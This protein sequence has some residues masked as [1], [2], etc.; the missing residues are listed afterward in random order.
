MIRNLTHAHWAGAWLLLFISFAVQAQTELRQLAGPKKVFIGN[1]I[2]NEHLNAPDTFRGGLADQHLIEQYNAV[3]LENYMK[4]R[5][6]LPNQSPANIHDLT[7]Q[8]LYDIMQKDRVMAFLNNPNW[9][10][11][12]KRGIAI[13]FNQAPS[14]LNIEAPAWTG[15]QVFDFSRKYIM[16][17]GQLCGDH[18]EEWDVINEAIA[19]SPTNGIRGWRQN[20]WYRRANDGSMTDWGV[21]TYENYIKMLFV[22]MREAQ[23]EARLHI[24]DYSIEHYETGLDSKNR[25]MREKVKALKDCGAPID[26]VGFQSHLLLSQMVTEQG[27]VDQSFINQIQQSMADLHDAGLEVAITELDIRI[28]NEDRDEAYQEAAFQA[29]CEM[30][31]SQPNCHEII[32]WGLRDE[33]NWITNINY[34]VFAGCQDPVLAEGAN[35]TLKAAFDGVANAITSLPDESN[36]NFSPLNPGDGETADCGGVGEILPSVFHVNGPQVVGQ[37]EEVTVPV[38]YLTAEEQDIIV[39]LELAADPYTSYLEER[40]TVPAGAGI[41]DAEIMIP[42]DVP[43]GTNAYRFYAYMTEVGG[44]VASHI[45]VRYQPNITVLDANSEV[46]ISTVGPTTIERG[47]TTEIEIKYSAGADQEIVVWFQLDEAPYTT[48]T[49]FRQSAMVGINTMTASLDIP[50]DVPIAEDAYQFQAVLVP[51]GGS[52]PERIS[53]RGQDNVSVTENVGLFNPSKEI[54]TLQISPNP[55]TDWATINLQK[56]VRNSTQIAITDM[57]GKTISMH[58]LQVNE[59]QARIDISGLQAGC[60]IVYVNTDNGIHSAVLIKGK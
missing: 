44:N 4:M 39:R 26:G 52:W 18:I 54:T 5:Y 24:N 57:L 55:T 10:D 35:Y 17:M 46:I 40:F 14:W 34:G 31:W 16:A 25:F 21:A 7:T 37:G 32:I 6:I 51:T 27:V 42:N 41:L 59:K 9:S 38:H 33:D 48:Y 58:P 28:C 49:E 50:A 22:W 12:R 2:S 47:T 56:P 3:V 8:E 13:W 29:F 43:G 20:T 23:P 45:S 53:F 19:S 30:A 60:Y 11:M 15:Q 36:Y 1:I